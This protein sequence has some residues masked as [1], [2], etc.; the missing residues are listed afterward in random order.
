MLLG[1]FIHLQIFFCYFG[2]LGFF[3][4]LMPIC[5]LRT[6]SW[7]YIQSKS[8]F[9]K[10]YLYLSSCPCSSGERAVVHIHPVNT[11]DVAIVD[12]RRNVFN[13]FSLLS[14]EIELQG[15]VTQCDSLFYPLDFLFNA[16]YFRFERI[17]NY[18]F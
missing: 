18:D 1:F 13:F 16:Y 4:Q 17:Q 15:P 12:I 5:S 14:A 6:S 9:E 8:T 3:Y 10:Q 11:S 7:C 2:F